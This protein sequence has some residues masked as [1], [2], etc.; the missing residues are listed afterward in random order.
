M[1]YVVSAFC[2]NIKCSLSFIVSIHMCGCIPSTRCL[3]HCLC[4]R[5]PT[6]RRPTAFL[7]ESTA[8]RS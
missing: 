8:G 4:G 5:L 2:Q 6:E 3:F 1:A 7:A